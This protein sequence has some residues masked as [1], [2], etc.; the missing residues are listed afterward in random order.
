MNTAV[1]K[2][3]NYMHVVDDL[4]EY[5]DRRSMALQSALHS[6]NRHLHPGAKAT[7]PDKNDFFNR[8]NSNSKSG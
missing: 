4:V 1:S 5:V 7:R 8:H 2:F 6:F 3:P